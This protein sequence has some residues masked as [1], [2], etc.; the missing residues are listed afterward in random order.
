MGH[1]KYFGAGRDGLGRFFET[2]VNDKFLGKGVLQNY[3]KVVRGTSF[4]IL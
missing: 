4:F 2:F 1:K 3:F